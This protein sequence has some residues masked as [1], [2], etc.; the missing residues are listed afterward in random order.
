MARLIRLSLL[1]LFVTAAAVAQPERQSMNMTL[2]DQFEPEVAIQG[3]HSALWGYAAPGGREYALFGT[4]DGVHI[5]DVTTA[6]VQEVAYVW[7]PPSSWREI[8]VYK[9]YAYIISES[10]DSGGGLQIVDLS[11]LPNGVQHIRTD[12]SAFIRAHTLFVRDHYLYVMG[13]QAVSG[14]N[15]GA[16]IFDLEPDPLHPRRVGQV[17]PHYFHD[18]WVR[19]DTLLGA[20]MFNGGCD[21]FDVRDKT[22]PVYLNTIT[23]P[24]SGTHNCEMTQDGGYV[25]TTDEVGLTP[26]TLKVW[27]IRDLGNITKVAEYTPNLSDVV[28]NVHVWG[29]Y[30]AVAWY[31]AGVRILDMIDPTHPREVGFYD[32]Y[33]EA[34]GGYNG[35]WEVYPYLPSGKLI[36]SDRQHG[37]FVMTFNN[38]IAGSIKGVVRN[39]A[40]NAPMPGVKVYVPQLGRVVVTDSQ[41]RY[42]VGT[43]QG[44]TLTLETREFGFGGTSLPVNISGDLQQDILLQ[45]LQ[46]IPVEVMA[47]D[48]SGVAVEGFN[49][50]VE[51]YIHSLRA[52]NGS[53]TVLLPLDSIF[54]VTIGK[55]G[56]EIQH[57]Q[58][59]SGVGARAVATLR[60]RYMDDATL[61]LGWDFSAPNDSTTR[62]GW[63]R[64]IA[65]PTAPPSDWLFPPSQPGGAVGHVFQAGP[66]PTE[67]PANYYDLNGRA[68]LTSPLMDLTNYGDP[69]IW[70]DLWFVHYDRDTVR[71]TM[72][73][74]L[75]NDDGGTWKTVYSE[76]KGRAGWITHAIFVTDHLA[77]TDRMRIRFVVS[78]TVGNATVMA[79]VDN[80]LVN[81]MRAAGVGGN[82]ENRK[83]RAG[84]MILSFSPN[85]V[86]VGEELRVVIAESSKG[87]RVE[88]F[89]SIGQR[90]AVLHDGPL[91]AGLHGFTMDA[92]L[93]AGNYLLRVMD[94]E[95]RMEGYPVV[96]VR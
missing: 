39:G 91:A 58:V 19:N 84:G 67:A 9:N 44:E 72:L 78:D 3:P 86:R 65:R 48:E 21:I 38:A 59:K 93:P 13:T 27:D 56:Y 85:P 57:V 32:T 34:S 68:T 16:I 54:T 71:D 55:W 61:D 4:Q 25:M 22:K 37:L 53:A 6:P 17:D 66:V 87:M 76:I 74:Q 40:T 75:T 11:P 26:K 79:A 41:G 64:E 30:A 92:S 5:I 60:R 88:L 69:S 89:N 95:G 90:V 29:R 70:Y 50:A 80:L 52:S 1:L 7:G 49:Y 77:L 20:A 62:G 47:K 42:Y 23:Y 15:G 63:M 2:F 33:P 28:H 8:K 12:T 31:T 51:P 43:A 10:S 36:A 81:M 35:V 24:L 73:V 94:G 45:P 18:A 46:M 14:A 96:V 82:D 83:A